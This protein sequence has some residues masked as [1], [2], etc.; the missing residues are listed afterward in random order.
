MGRLGRT[1]GVL[2]RLLLIKDEFFFPTL[3]VGTCQFQS[4]ELRV[5]EQVG[6]QTMNVAMASPLWIIQSVLDHPH[7]DTAAV[8]IS[9]VRRGINLGEKRAI[10]QLLDGRRIRLLLRRMRSLMPRASSSFQC[11]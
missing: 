9:I 8:L 5:I 1:S 7:D 11:A 3:V 6:R 10:R 2:V 4:G